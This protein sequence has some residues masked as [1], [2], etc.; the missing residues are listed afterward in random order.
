VNSS[1]RCI[2][3]IILAMVFFFPALVAVDLLIPYTKASG[4]YRVDISSVK[5][6]ENTIVGYSD[7]ELKKSVKLDNLSSDD[8]IKQIEAFSVAV[9]G[10]ADE[11]AISK[12]QETIE[13]ARSYAISAVFKRQQEVESKWKTLVFFSFDKTAGTYEFVAIPIDWSSNKWQK[14][15]GSA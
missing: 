9:L 11:V 4:T 10:G 6:A 14:C 3:G 5:I 2:I 13:L 7:L 8:L 15:N 1:T 12:D